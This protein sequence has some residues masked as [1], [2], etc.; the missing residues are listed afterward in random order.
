MGLDE[1]GSRFLL[2]A[3]R[4]GVDFQRTLMIGRQG[5]HL[6]PAKLAA[7]LSEF[8]LRTSAD[9]AR[10]ML[11]AEAGFAEPLLTRLGAAEISPLDASADEGATHVHDLN[12]PIGDELKGRFSTVLDGGTLEHVF[13][14]PTALKSC[15]EMVAPGG[16]YLALTP[17]S[18]FS[19][20]GFYQFSP[21]LYYRAFSSENGYRIEQ[22][23]LYEDDA[24]S[25]W[26]RVADPSVLRS[27]VTFLSPARTYLALIARRL[28]AAPI[29]RRWPQQSDYSA[30]WSGD[31]WAKPEAP[32][33][34]PIVD[35]V[36]RTVKT[37]AALAFLR[38]VEQLYRP[39]DYAFPPGAFERFDPLRD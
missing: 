20:H 28:E 16:H 1:N 2:Y 24:E 12:L 35:L 6:P 30:R 13:N 14:F 19:G 4:A 26:Y 17:A 21:E 9:D 33:R 29:F 38:R 39:L 27:R 32:R 36:R 3:R 18:N 5:L 8:G 10:R 25:A 11:D 23:V 7:M 31:A 34:R 37:G 22:M 15:M